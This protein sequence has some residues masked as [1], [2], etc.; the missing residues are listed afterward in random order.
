MKKID[1]EPIGERLKRLREK[2]G[3]SAIDVAKAI[4]VPPSTYREWEYGR[5]IRGE[6]YLKLANVL[7]VSLYELMTGAPPSIDY[8]IEMLVQI[9]KLV[10][11]IRVS[12]NCKR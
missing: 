3:L 9:E 11:E 4:N 6:P 12:L 2:K 8:N 7:D 1:M 5:T 10:K